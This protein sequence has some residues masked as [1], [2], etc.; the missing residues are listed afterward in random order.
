M[1]SYERGKVSLLLLL[2]LRERIVESHHEILAVTTG[3]SEWRALVRWS[4]RHCRVGWGV[5][6]IVGGQ[7]IGFLL[8]SHFSQYGGGCECQRRGRRSML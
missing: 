7:L 2:L 8:G 3:G 5:G 4:T 1:R 6:G